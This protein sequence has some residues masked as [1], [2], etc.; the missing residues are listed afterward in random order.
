MKQETR[1]SLRDI[2]RRFAVSEIFENKISISTPTMFVVDGVWGKWDSQKLVARI[3]DRITHSMVQKLLGVKDSE[4]NNV[5]GEL[6][7]LLKGLIERKMKYH[8]LVY[9]NLTIVTAYMDFLVEITAE[10]GADM[11]K[12]LSRLKPSMVDDMVTKLLSVEPLPALLS[13]VYGHEMDA[14]YEY[15]SVLTTRKQILANAI[16][17]QKMLVTLEAI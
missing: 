3:K 17:M 2:V 1:D 7:N 14:P 6:R 11:K 5:D 15:P 8:I 9:E 16:E 10:H 4:L 13:G 12:L